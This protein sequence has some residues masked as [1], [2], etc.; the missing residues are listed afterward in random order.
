MLP[1]DEA[2][3]APEGGVTAG[4]ADALVAGVRA[5]RARAIGRAISEVERDCRLDEKVIRHI[6]VMHEDEPPTV[7]TTADDFDQAPL[8]REDDDL[9][10][11]LGRDE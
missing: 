10:L 7:G 4:R 3:P 1:V 2:A 6:I 9:G 8:R 11:G 5:G